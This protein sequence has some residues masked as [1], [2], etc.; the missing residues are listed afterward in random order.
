MRK[1]LVTGGSGFIGS[2]LVEELLGRGVDHRSICLLVP[3]GDSLKNLPP[4][5]FEI[6]VG[7][8]RDKSA[9]A[10]AAEGAQIIYHLAAKTIFEVARRGDYDSVNVQGTQNLL[11]VA[12]EHLQKFVLF[13]SIA[14]Y[15]LPAYVGPIVNWNETRTKKPSEPYGESKLEAEKRVIQWH[16][17][18][19]QSY[20]II[21]PT[22]VYGPRD[23]QGILELY[24]AIRGHYYLPIGQGKNLMDYV[25][26]KDLVRGACLAQVGKQHDSDYILGCG[27]PETSSEIARQVAKSIGMTIASVRIP[28]LLA[29][30]VSYPIAWLGRAFSIKVPL[31]PNRVKVLSTDCYYDVSQAKTEIGYRPRTSFA[32]GAKL[33]GRWLVA[34][35]MI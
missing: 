31:Y 4:L 19:G 23:H 8:V 12:S 11:N 30:G 7:D 15:G 2:H 14:V 1:I 10:K 28:K 5:G 35:G 13:S 9:V 18:T 29:L 33:T 22:T 26:V 32:D 3:P 34:N 25:F 16:Q 24:R 21:R 6:V 20:T 27:N 17:L